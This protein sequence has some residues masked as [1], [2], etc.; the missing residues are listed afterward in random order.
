MEKTAL[1]QFIEAISNSGIVIIN[2]TLIDNCLQIEKN[3][4][5]D[6]HIETM[7][8]GLKFENSQDWDDKY[9]PKIKS[10]SEKT[11]NKTFKSE[12]A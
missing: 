10:M 5:I 6:L 1:Q 7:K 9:L 12:K 3:Q 11:W 4:F 8:E 2:Q